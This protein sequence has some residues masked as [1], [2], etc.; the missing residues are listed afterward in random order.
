VYPALRVEPGR[1]LVTPVFLTLMRTYGVTHL[2]SP[3]DVRGLEP[4]AKAADASAARVYRVPGAARVRIAEHALPAAD[5]RSAVKLLTDPS[6]DP[7]VS[8]VLNDPP[9]APAAVTTTSSS[10]L[11]NVARIE[12]D[13]REQLVVRARAP[14]GGY[15]VLADTYYPGWHAEIDGA[16]TPIARANLSLRAVPLPP[17]EHRVVFRYQPSW[18]ALGRASRFSALSALVALL[19]GA[20]WWRQRELDRG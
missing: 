11:P 17:G 19:G 2:I 9:L 8:V 18:L 12:R 10:S 1:L 4:I 14:R 3:F 20:L 16:P 13:A 6:F 7:D 15:L 5:T